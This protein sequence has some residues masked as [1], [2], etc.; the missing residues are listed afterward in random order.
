MADVN[1]LFWNSNNGDRRYN[2]DSLSEWLRK[3]FTTGVFNGEM[4]VTPVS[5]MN[6][7]VATGYA[8]IQGKVRFFDTETSFTVPTANSTYPRIDTVVVQADYTNRNI[9]LVYVQGAYSGNNP[10]P[11]APVRDTGLYQIVLAQIYVAAGATEITT[12]NITDTRSDSDLCGWVTGTVEGVPVDQIVSQMTAQFMEFFE[13]MK[14]QL[15]QDAAGH[16]QLEIDELIS[17]L[18]ALVS[19]ADILTGNFA[20]IEE[21]PA[22][23]AHSVGDFIV[24]NNQ[25]YKVT[26]AV[27]VGDTLEVGTNIE[28][29]S[30]GT[31]ITSLYKGLMSVQNE[32]RVKNITLQSANSAVTITAQSAKLFGNVLAVSVTFTLSSQVS[33]YGNLISLGG[34]SASAGWILPV[35]TAGMA[36]VTDQS[37]YGDSGNTN[38]RASRNLPAGTYRIGGII[39][40]N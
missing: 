21:S 7:N 22:V 27:A 26:A 5:G 17:S 19:R 3:F 9:S 25:L 16:L 12:A 2:A 13:H 40:V 33:I 15:D 31:E 32:L 36:P 18:S 11:Q 6:I 34:K 10:E 24:Y 30:A 38:V 20:Q 23:A 29:T 14:D 8:N 39:L 1:G 35:Y 37:V 4:Q 28:S